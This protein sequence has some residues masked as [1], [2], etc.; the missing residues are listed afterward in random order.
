M[1][2]CKCPKRK[3]TNLFCFEHRVNVCE[4][5][6][7]AN[8]ESC[9]VQTYL[10]WLTDSDY[11]PSCLLCSDLLPSREP[12]RLKCF[13]VFHWDCLNAR[14]A[15]LPNTTAPAGYK[16]PSCLDVVFPTTNQS[17][18]VVDLLRSKL[19]T[20]NWAR[21]GLGLQILPELESNSMTNSNLRPNASNFKSPQAEFPKTERSNRGSFSVNIEGSV[22]SS[23]SDPFEGNTYARSKVA[24]EQNSLKHNH[25][26]PSMERL[27]QSDELGDSKYA[28][29]TERGLRHKFARL[30]RSVK[31]ILLA[32]LVLA[33]I[34]LII[35]RM[36][37]DN[38]N[39]MFDPHA[40]PHIRVESN[41]E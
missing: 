38:S 21:N 41:G 22:E 1:G 14:F 6:L 5:C 35:S 4:Y 25:R 24:N 32:L 28:K 13:H 37:S 9:V 15:Q 7:V 39:P 16:C 23:L 26:A 19:E 3:V 2:L 17:S 29:R 31:R 34:Y 8:H 20:V 36:G 40:N 27:L 30:P 12:I 33:F 11:D 18:P 10:S